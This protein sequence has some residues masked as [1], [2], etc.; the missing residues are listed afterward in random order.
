MG[1]SITNI[2]YVKM[3]MN[4][5]SIWNY[6]QMGGNKLLTGENGPDENGKETCAIA[7]RNLKTSRAG[8]RQEMATH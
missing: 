6:V 1:I 8:A 3:P 7:D 2:S 5:N 4:V